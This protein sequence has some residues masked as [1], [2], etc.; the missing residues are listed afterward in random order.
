[1]GGS[2]VAYAESALQEGCGGFAEL[3]YEAH[4]IVEEGIVIIVAG[5]NFSGIV[6]G[7]G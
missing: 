1:V 7:A 3:D 2:A 4:G 6:V 5:G